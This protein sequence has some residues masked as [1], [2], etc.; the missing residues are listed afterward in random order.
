MN[1]A[2]FKLKKPY[3]IEELAAHIKAIDSTLG[4]T[5]TLNLDND[6]MEIEIY[7]IKDYSLQLTDIEKAV[8][9][10]YKGKTDEQLAAEAEEAAEVEKLFK[11]LDKEKVKARLKGIK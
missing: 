6:E 5:G 3:C 10:H 1:K 11:L 4:F 8:K 7:G 2:I 9:E